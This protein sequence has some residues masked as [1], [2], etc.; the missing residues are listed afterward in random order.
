HG[1]VA[2][3]TVFSGMVSTGDTVSVFPASI[4]VRVRS[5][6]AQNRPAETGRSGERC[7]LT[8]SGI[9]KSPV[10]RGDWLA[11]PTLLSPTTRTDTRRSPL[12]AADVILKPWSTVPFPHGAGHFIAP[13]VPLDSAAIQAGHSCYAQMVFDTPI[14]AV[15]G[16]RFILRDAQA[17]H[18]LGGG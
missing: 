8:L 10:K 9:E 12:P 15:P 18:T 4:P 5:I 7:A 17:L 14:C 3:G 13:V 2:A 6:H 1:T 11:H 16:D